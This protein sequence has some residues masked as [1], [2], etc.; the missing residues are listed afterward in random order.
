MKIM[1]D[2]MNSL[3]EHETVLIKAQAMLFG[4]LNA[5]EQE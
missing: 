4:G 2:E 3:K 1:I 5:N